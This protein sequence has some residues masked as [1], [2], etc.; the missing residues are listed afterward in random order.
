MDYLYAHD[1][2]VR[3]SMVRKLLIRKWFDMH[4]DGAVCVNNKWQIQLKYDPDLQK[5][6]KTGFLKQVREHRIGC[7]HPDGWKRYGKGQTY[8]VKA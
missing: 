5:L 4:P 7:R 8:L 6:L 1:L 2:P 3:F